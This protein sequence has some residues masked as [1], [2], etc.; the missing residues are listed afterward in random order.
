MALTKIDDRGLKTP[1]DL[2][3]NEKIRFGTGNDLEIYHDGSHSYIK[4]TGTGQLVLCTDSFRVNN[5]ANSE[6]IITA[7]ENGAVNL[8]YDDSK[9]LET[10]TYGIKTEG[11]VWLSRDNDQAIFGPD[12]DL[13]IYHSGAHS[14]VQHDGTG[15][16]YIDAIGASVNLRSGD[17]AGGVHNS[18]VCNMNAGIELYYDNGLKAF[19]TST[20][21]RIAGILY[22]NGDGVYDLGKS[23]ERWEDV[24]A[25]NGT[26]QTS[27]RNEKNTIVESDLG[28]N[29]VNKLKPV[30]YKW[31][32]ENS[33]TH[34][35][36]IAQDIEEIL[37]TEG[38]TDK[39]FAALNIPTEGPMGLNYSELISPLIKAV[40]ELSTE[41]ET[42]KTK[43]A[44]LE[45]K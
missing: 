4:D 11:H 9:K 21:F 32:R 27:D 1:I 29:F 8:F 19:T 18:V 6:N 44:A 20:G 42:L 36:L 12:S 35:G 13:K 10:Y 16:L 38:K 25:T 14:H 23:N 2:L 26:I 28:L 3:D 37:S 17:N 15:N 31:N 34:Y 33:K 40:Q 5:A 7:E 24:Y 30:S 45:A 39:D 43:V 41:V 22:P